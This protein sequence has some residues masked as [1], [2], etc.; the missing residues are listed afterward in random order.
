MEKVINYIKENEMIKSGEIIGVACSG[1]RDSISLLHYLNSI[2]SEL[3][4]E[5]VAINVDHGIRQSSALDTE[6]V[7]QF[8]KEHKI[9]AYKFKGEALK[10]AKEEK[11]TVEQAARKVR[12]GIFE[13][14]VQKGVC[15]KI[16]LAHH[17]YD[18]AETVLLN[19]LRGAGLKGARGM[20]PVRDNIYIRPLLAT[21]RENIMAYIDEFGLEYVEDETNKDTTYS[22][23]YLRNIVMPALRRHFKGAD[24]S[25]VNF[26][27]LC[28]KDDD[29]INSKI[30]VNTMIETKDFVK[31][32]L[33]YFY[34]DEAVV[35][36]IL[37]K[38]FERFSRQDFERKHVNIVRNFAL[39]ADNGSIIS[40]P[41]KVRALKEYD[42]IVIGYIKKKENI[43]EYAFQSGKLKID[44]YG[45]IRS[46]SSKVLTEPKN[47]QHIIDAEKLPS[48]AAWR[49]RKEGDVF[50]PLGLGGTKKLKEYFI[51]KKIPQRMR[52]EI[53]VLAV[54]D[55]ILIVADVEIA[56]ELKVTPE[57]K[58]YYKVNYEKDLV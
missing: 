55:K 15:D 17:M 2:K 49:F 53:P 28:A 19:I 24:K 30:D 42:Y 26:A 38:V 18:Q 27:A 47:H 14:V 34:Q 43:G 50:S 31:V 4:C 56:D 37:M 13:T 3:D 36:R 29:Y 51:D 52:N 22:R 35:N 54:G 23:N 9:R 12:Y 20:E 46:T 32:P 48:N 1:G 33:T 25:L 11:L 41:F 57:T 8:C 7:M 10:V 16:A 58:R 45:I 40:L 39:E 5:V 21:P 6:F 44:G